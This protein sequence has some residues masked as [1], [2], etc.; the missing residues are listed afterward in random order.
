MLVT[1]LV[2]QHLSASNYRH[3]ALEILAMELVGLFPL[4]SVDFGSDPFIYFLKGACMKSQAVYL[5]DMSEGCID[6][7]CALLRYSREWISKY[8]CE[9]MHLLQ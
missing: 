5:T 4:P 3:G 7:L 9:E 8:L 2:F 6:Y 1:R